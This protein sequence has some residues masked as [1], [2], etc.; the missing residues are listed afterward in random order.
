MNIW[1]SLR[2]SEFELRLSLAIS[3]S[4]NITKAARTLGVSLATASA[5]LAAFEASLG[6][7]LFH[8][9]TRAVTLTADGEAFMPYAEMALDAL[10]QGKAAASGRTAGISGLLRM[11]APASFGRMHLLPL[12]PAFLARH[13]ALRLDVRLTD[14]VMD[15]VEAGIDLGIRNAAL[16]DSS[17]IARKLLDDDRLLVAGPAFVRRHALTVPADL[18][19]TPCIVV[20]GADRWRFADGTVVPVRPL[21]RINDGEA[22]RMAAEA[23]LGVALM[24][25]W[26]AGR[27]LAAGQLVPVLEHCPLAATES[28]WAVYPSTR[29]LAPKVRSM[30][31]YL[32][33]CFRGRQPWET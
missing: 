14:E 32:A 30:I 25:R 12:L 19:R 26:N 27:A 21:M 18:E 29:L 5:R 4:G 24:S 11:T 33:D 10:E 8:R 15:L 31:D 20:G 9:T 28:V 23:G 6:V 2:M 17:F 16:P 1:P 13:P 22:A 3:R 7:R